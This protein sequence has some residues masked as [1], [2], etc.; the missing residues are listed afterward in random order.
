MHGINASMEVSDV[1]CMEFEV[2]D[3]YIALFTNRNE[4]L[5]QLWLLYIM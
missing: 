2:I 5:I 1:I 4:H 3:V